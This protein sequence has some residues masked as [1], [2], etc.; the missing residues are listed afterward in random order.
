MRNTKRLLACMLAG[1]MALSVG[2]IAPKTESRAEETGPLTAEDELKEILTFNLPENQFHNF[3]DKVTS[4]DI[5]HYDR[6]NYYAYLHNTAVHCRAKNAKSKEDYYDIDDDGKFE[7]FINFGKTYN[8]YAFNGNT[9]SV[10]LIKTF[11]KVNAIYENAK[12]KQIT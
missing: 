7:L 9:Y 3:D 2:V 4:V 1:V 11:N 12:K 10:P 6:N 8:L 5:T